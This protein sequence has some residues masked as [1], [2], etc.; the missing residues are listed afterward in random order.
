[1]SD[2]PPLILA[3]G[4]P[5]RAQMLERLGLPFRSESPDVDETP[6][7]GERPAD[8]ALRL[9]T[10]KARTVA[11]L[12]PDSVVI[13]GDQV[14]GL[15]AEIFGKPG[16]RDAAIAQLRSMRGRTVCWH[17]GIAIV[18]P[19]R[20]FSDVVVTEARFRELSDG[21][22]ER[23]VDF[24]RPFD[25]AGAMR[26]ESR[27]IAL[28]DALSSDDPSALIGLPLIRISGWLRTLGYRCP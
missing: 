17:S 18:A 7:G 6:R 25:C 23:Y 21:E 9:A 5:Y 28:L 20:E 16:D 26:S 8:L 3:S 11:A 1:M 24:D 13:A 22:I 15:D 4:S 10:D 12:F 14:A 2:A 27:G 19:S